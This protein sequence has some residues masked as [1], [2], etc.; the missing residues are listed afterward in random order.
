L[1]APQVGSSSPLHGEGFAACFVLSTGFV[2]ASA[3]AALD[4]G[5]VVVLS[6]VDCVSD[7]GLE[8]VVAAFL[9]LDLCLTTVGEAGVPAVPWS[10]V[11]LPV[12]A[13]VFSLSP[14]V[15]EGSAAGAAAGVWVSWAAESGG[16]VTVTSSA[17]RGSASAPLAKHNQARN[18]LNRTVLA[19]GALPQHRCI[20]R[21][22]IISTRAKTRQTVLLCLFYVHEWGI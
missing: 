10:A 13:G 19:T 16:T 1:F 9:S 8:S 5:A 18:P 6:A 2:V 14:P 4:G 7:F 12:A 15:N 3:G 21:L 22:I 11:V 20:C 17:D